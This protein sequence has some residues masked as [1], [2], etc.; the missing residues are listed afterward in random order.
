[1]KTVTK[2]EFFKAVSHLDVHPSIRHKRW[3]TGTGYESDW[4]LRNGTVIGYTCKGVYK[5]AAEVSA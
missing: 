1:M 5:L 3:A 4:K 2:E